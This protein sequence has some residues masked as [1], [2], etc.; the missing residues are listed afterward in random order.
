M[1]FDICFLVYL[2]SSN[3]IPFVLFPLPGTFHWM[4]VGGR[5][6]YLWWYT[7][8]ETNIDPSKTIFGDDLLVLWRVVNLMWQGQVLT[9][10]INNMEPKKCTPGKG[11]WSS[12][13]PFSGS[14]LVFQGVPL[15]PSLVSDYTETK[16]KPSVAPARQR[17]GPVTGHRK[18]QDA[19]LI[20]LW[21]CF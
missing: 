15:F 20:D 9:W 18:L 1:L 6:C 11:N 5:S 7:L 17:Q 8:P 4:G 16:V 19:V 10:K 12:N 14:I 21:Y 13:S 3:P 2:L